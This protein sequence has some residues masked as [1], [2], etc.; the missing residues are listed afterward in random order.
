MRVSFRRVRDGFPTPYG[1]DLVSQEA[2]S[3]AEF[4]PF[5]WSLAEAIHHAIASFSNFLADIRMKAF[6]FGGRYCSAKKHARLDEYCFVPLIDYNDLELLL[7]WSSE[8]YQAISPQ[9]RKDIVACSVDCPDLLYR[10]HG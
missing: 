2:D 1:L 5:L 9:I 3:L 7:A 4:P 8:N 10:E 6:I